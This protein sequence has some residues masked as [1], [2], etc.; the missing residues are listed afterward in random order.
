MTAWE[1]DAMEEI[2]VAEWFAMVEKAV[3]WLLAHPGKGSL[4][5][6]GAIADTP[7]EQAC[8]A[9]IVASANERL[10]FHMAVHRALRVHRRAADR[11]RSP[12]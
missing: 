4:H 9:A 5:A 1:N 6:L 8:I 12:A 3:D 11:H 7:A 2:D 10:A